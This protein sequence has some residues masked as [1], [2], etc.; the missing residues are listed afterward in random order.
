MIQNAEQGESLGVLNSG[1]SKR[2]AEYEIKTLSA[3][4]LGGVNDLS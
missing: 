4:P 1:P 2:A 3:H